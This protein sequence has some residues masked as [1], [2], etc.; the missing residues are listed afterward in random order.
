MINRRYRA[1]GWV[2][3]VAA[4]GLG[5]WFAVRPGPATVE[6][7]G[8]P[9]PKPESDRPVS[10]AEQLQELKRDY[11][12]VRVEFERAC[13]AAKTDAERSAARAR[14]HEQAQALARR[15]LDLARK[16]PGEPAAFDALAWVTTGGLGHSPETAA[17]FEA[18]FDLLVRD[19][20]GSEK[21]GPV[22]GFASVYIGETTG[23]EKLLRAALGSNPH[24]D[25]R[26]IACLSLADCLWSYAK[27]SARLRHPAKA[28]G[29]KETLAPGVVARLRAADPDR[30][31]EEAEELFQRTIAEYGDVKAPRY[32]GIT[33]DDA[34]PRPGLGELARAPLF[35]MRNL[36]VGK[37][38]PEIEGEDTDGRKFRLSDYRGKA[39]VLDFWGAW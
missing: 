35:E 12:K 28:E 5:V 32:E 3:L 6:A 36:V 8:R 10:L 39:V 15:A 7:P 17:E 30:L 16:A 9:E 38:A 33:Y 37:V 19:H 21:L 20:I 1:L 25:V 11:E 29:L 2:S 22:C 24:R 4:A 26:G 27:W 31:A 34:A 18:A 23:A 13:D 14:E